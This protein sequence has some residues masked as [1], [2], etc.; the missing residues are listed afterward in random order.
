MHTSSISTFELQHRDQRINLIRWPNGQAGKRDTV[1]Q[2]SAVYAVPIT[3]RVVAIG[4]WIDVDR[5]DAERPRVVISRR[6]RRL[7]LRRTLAGKQTVKSDTRT[8]VECRADMDK[9][10]RQMTDVATKRSDN[11]GT[12]ERAR[13]SIAT[14]NVILEFRSGRRRAERNT[15]GCRAGDREIFPTNLRVF[16]EVTKTVTDA[17]HDR[18]TFRQT[19]AALM[20]LDVFVPGIGQPQVMVKQFRVVE[21]RQVR[22]AASSRCRDLKA[23]QADV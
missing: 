3:I 15:I 1:V 5:R 19:I 9:V 21:E 14:E 18:R 23:G 16:S 11:R 20:T 8:E 2:E 4:D 7:V 13:R 12:T 6:P 17:R 10:A 22:S